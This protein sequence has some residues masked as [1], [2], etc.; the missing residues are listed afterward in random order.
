MVKT[1]ALE[2]PELVEQLD[3]VGLGDRVGQISDQQFARIIH[4]VGNVWLAGGHIASDQIPTM[5][6][7]AFERPSSTEFGLEIVL[8][9]KL[10]LENGLG[11]VVEVLAP[12]GVVAAAGLVVLPETLLAVLFGLDDIVQGH[13][14]FCHFE[15]VHGG[16][17]GEKNRKT[18]FV[19]LFR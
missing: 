15:G 17:I 7:G 6:R 9:G 1:G 10:R 13:V 4:G 11:V 2:D 12:P 14:H 8:M 16:K 18:K 5:R 19:Y 3:D